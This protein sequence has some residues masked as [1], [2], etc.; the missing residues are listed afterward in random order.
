MAP[1]FLPA[2]ASQSLGRAPH[3]KIETKLALI[4]AAGFHAIELFME[5]L[6]LVATRMREATYPP[7]SFIDSTSLTTD[8]YLLAAAKYIRQLCQQHNLDILCLQPFMNFEGLLSPSAHAARLRELHLWIRLAQ[9]LHTDLI[10]IPSSFLPTTACTGDREQIVSDLRAVA[11][12]GLAHK[13]PIRFA[14]EALAW[15]THTDRWDQAYTIVEKVDRP[16]F[17]TCLDTFNLLGR[18]YADPTVPSGETPDAAAALSRT[19]HALRTRLDP[20]KIFYI[21]AC[22]G[23]R[24]SAPLRPGHPFHDPDQPARM[25]WSRNARLFPCEVSGYLPVRETLQAIV[26]AGFEGYVSFEFFSRSAQQA[27]PEVPPEH[28]RRAQLS[29]RRMC[30]MMDWEDCLVDGGRRLEEE[31][32][33]RAN[34]PATSSTNTPVVDSKVSVREGHRVGLSTPLQAH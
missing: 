6:E 13:P 1:R 30:K 5:D 10:Q 7:D 2:I 24:L 8:D 17:G 18:E 23:E 32:G 19:L 9:H 15:A 34:E 26:D 28:A 33:S 3:H 4:A 31:E 21:E 22:D 29:W 20:A 16:N 25:S 27:G 11:D 14:Y 12:I